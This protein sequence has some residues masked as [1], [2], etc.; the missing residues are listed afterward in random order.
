MSRA[1]TSLSVV[2]GAGFTALTTAITN[3]SVYSGDG[4]LVTIIPIATALLIGVNEMMIDADGN[5]D[6]LPDGLT[7]KEIRDL[8]GDPDA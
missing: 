5:S 4:F 6:D 3:L 8:G 2:L 7:E 1:V